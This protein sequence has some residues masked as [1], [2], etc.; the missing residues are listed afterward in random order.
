MPLDPKIAGLLQFIASAGYPPMSEGTADQARAGLRALM[1]D[2]RDVSTLAPV[3]SVTP[4]TI[5]GDL[6]VRVYRPRAARR[7]RRSCTSTAAGS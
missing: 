2:V 7:S 3:A 5:A 6:P 4:T 1:V